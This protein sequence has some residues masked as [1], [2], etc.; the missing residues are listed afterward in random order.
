MENKFGGMT[1]NERLYHSNLLES[2]DKLIELKDFKGLEEIL[3]KIELD[4]SSI[5]DIINSLKPK[6]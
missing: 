1:V 4:D 2:F 3:K 5:E 6:Q